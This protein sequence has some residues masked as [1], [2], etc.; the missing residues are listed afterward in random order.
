MTSAS[1]AEFPL[2]LE[3]VR[4]AQSRPRE[5]SE[6]LVDVQR[7]LQDRSSGI[8][9]L[10]ASH[11]GLA[12][13]EFVSFQTGISAALGS[14]LP[15]IGESGKLFRL[16]SNERGNGREPAPRSE[17]R[18]HTDAPYHNPVPD[19]V[20]LGKLEDTTGVRSILLNI[21]N[22]PGLPAALADPRSRTLVDWK[23]P[24]F[25]GP[26]EYAR[27]AA[28]GIGV[29][30]LAPV[31]EGDG[32]G[33]TMRFRFRPYDAM[34]RQS[35]VCPPYQVEYLEKIASSVA[36]CVGTAEIAFGAHDVLVFNNKWVLHGRESIDTSTEFR[37][38][39][40]RTRGYLRSE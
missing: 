29:G 38:T 23:E 7:V 11:L 32:D 21:H 13:E 24:D 12:N 4:L 19:W 34:R 6:A 3:H 25:F 22:W 28:L 27:F 36:N 37:R 17:F 1:I 31:F 9:V 20:A 15:E 2:E 26:S 8:I 14:V 40:V 30:V 35:A 10:R 16:L 39:L 5:M 18:L 33:L